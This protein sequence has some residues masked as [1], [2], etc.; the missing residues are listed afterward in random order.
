MRKG[1]ITWILKKIKKRIPALAVLTLARTGSGLLGVLFALGSKAVIDSATAGDMQQ[2][3]EACLLQAGII[4]GILICL[5]LT[6]HIRDRL[7]ADL[8]WDWKRQMLHGVLHG[9]YET[10]ASYHSAELLNRMNNDVQKV[11][12]GILSVVP[13]AAGLLARLVAAVLVLDT[14][15]RSFLLVV[16]AVGTA[17]IAATALM[18]RRLKDLNKQVSRQDGK[19]SGY[20]QE[21]IEKI[22]LLQAMNLS[23]EV[24]RRAEGLLSQRY[25]VQKKR[26]NVSLVAN[27]CVSLMAYGSG[28]LALVWSAFRM[29]NGQ[30]TFGAMTAMIQLVDQLRLPFVNLSG[31]IPQYTA[32]IASA[33]RLMELEFVWDVSE[34]ETKDAA[35]LYGDMEEIRGKGLTFSYGRDMVLDNADFSLP[36]GSFTVITGHSGIGKST[37]LKLI[38]GVFTAEKGELYLQGRSQVPLNR[39]TR[40][41]FAYVPQGSFLFSGTIRDNLLITNPQAEER[42]IA[43]AIHVSGMDE[44]LRE[45]PNGLDTVLGENN[46]GLSEGQAQR[47]AIA[48][49]VLSGAPVLLLDECTSALDEELEEM[50]L[51]RLRD[52]PD[53]TFLAVTHRPAALQISDMQL[54]MEEG[55]IHTRSRKR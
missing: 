22:L 28:F 29:L 5:M 51:R 48:R 55:R 42:E 38:L 32:M 27:T 49:A 8:E 13:E 47:L 36:K 14:L 54:C 12:E 39:Q 11:N 21:T 1:K 46:A 4:L 44:F 24:E 7:M 3:W 33:E 25:Q 23:Q 9:E 30:M 26:K 45:L 53:R 41:L 6:R 20:L 17:V 34:V 31:I 43:E 2:F 15:D 18:R 19:V 50:V 35:A 40:K 16:L 52:L 37:L 10:V